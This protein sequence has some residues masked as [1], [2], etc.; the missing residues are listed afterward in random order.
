MTGFPQSAAYGK[1]IPFATLRRQG[2]A[3]RYGDFI[4]SLVWAYKLSPE[5]MQLAATDSVKEIEVMDLAVKDKCSGLRSLA[6]VISA[7][8]KIIPS[9]LIFRVFDEEGRALKIAFNLKTSGGVAHGESEVFRLFHTDETDHP[10]PQ[11]N[12]TLESF[13]KRFAAAV[14]GMTTSPDESLRD[15]DPRHYRLESLNA[16]LADIEKKISKQ[17]QLDRKYALAKER[18]EIEREAALCRMPNRREQER[19]S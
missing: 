7:L 4:K 16:E 6:A 1:K 11:G 8:D 19:Y 3:P 2:I 9:P 17:V 12:T 15:L 10:L 14:G 18:R 13:Y 5:T